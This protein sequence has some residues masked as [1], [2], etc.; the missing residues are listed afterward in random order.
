MRIAILPA[1]GGSKRIKNKN[2]IDFAGKPMMVHALE[3]T[4]ASG[5]FDAIHVSTD[6]ETI[7]QV[8]E[9]Y[10]FPVDFMRTP[11]LADD[12]VGLVPVLKW[13]LQEYQKRGKIFEDACCVFPAAPLLEPYDLIKAFEIYE[14]HAKA[15]PLLVMT[16]SKL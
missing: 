8:A 5:L 6:S 13:V 11:E 7:R 16:H 2:I 4:R 1:R 9:K 10:D 15:Y 3:A 12:F 14:K